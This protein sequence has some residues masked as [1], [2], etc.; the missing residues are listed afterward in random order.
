MEYDIAAISMV[1][2]ESDIIWSCLANLHHHGIRQFAIA[3]HRSTDSTVAEIEAFQNAFPDTSVV[4]MR[5]PAKGHTQS[6]VITAL[7]KFASSYF[8]AKYIFPFDADEFLV[9]ESALVQRDPKPY[10]PPPIS[11]LLDGAWDSLELDW[12]TCAERDD[13]AIIASRVPSKWKKIVIRWDDGMTV[14]Q[15]NHAVRSVRK[16][17]LGKKKS[18]HIENLS[19]WK[20]LHF[21]VRSLTQFRSKILNGGAANKVNEKGISSHWDVLFE[22]HRVYGESVLTDLHSLITSPSS[23][24][25]DFLAFVEKFGLDENLMGYFPEYFELKSLIRFTKPIAI[26]KPMLRDSHII[27]RH[28]HS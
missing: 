26:S 8:S 4:I 13:G 6:R 9:H 14:K 12:F 21:P 20:I 24:R 7:A 17:W 25:V 16:N 23:N 27:D 18:P 22:A 10:A 2:N 1:R 15:G 11:S 19:E 5:D 28:S 3:D